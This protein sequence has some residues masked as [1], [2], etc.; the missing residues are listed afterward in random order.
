MIHF[1]NVASC[2][3]LFLAVVDIAGGAL[4]GDGRQSYGIIKLLYLFAVIW[5]LSQFVF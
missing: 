4:I 1:L 2:V 5:L 3:L